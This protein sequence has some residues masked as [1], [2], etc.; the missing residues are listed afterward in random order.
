MNETLV[1][2]QK[3]S[4]RARTKKN[5]G[6]AR[7]LSVGEALQQMQERVEREQEEMKAKERYHILR[8]KI[9]FAKLVWKE[10]Q[11][12]FDVFC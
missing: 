9:G 7:V 1:E 11:M 12:S 4:R 10:L 2:K 5:F 6:E 8:G 3:N